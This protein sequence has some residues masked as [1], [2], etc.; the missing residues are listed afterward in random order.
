MVNRMQRLVRVVDDPVSVDEHARIRGGGDDF[1]EAGVVGVFRVLLV[2]EPA[3]EPRT[4][5]STGAL[6]LSVP[7]AKPWKEAQ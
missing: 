5:R 7:M 4:Q 2:D 1:R 3:F 6:D